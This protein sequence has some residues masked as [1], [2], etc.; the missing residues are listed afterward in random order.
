MADKSFFVDTTRCSACHGC[1]VICKQWN[2]LPATRTKNRGSYQ[3]PEDL[4]SSTFKLVR[5]NEVVSGGKLHWYFF[6]DQCR[7]CLVPPCKE[8]AEGYVDGAIVLDKVTGAVLYTE[9]TKKLDASAFEEI[10]DACPYNIP[11]RNSATGMISKCTMCIDRVDNGL[12]PACVKACPTGAMNF[13][14]RN[15]MLAQAIKRVAEL[16]R[17]GFNKAQL[18]NSDSVRVIYLVVDDPTAYHEFAVDE[19]DVGICHHPPC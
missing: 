16:K 1:Q 19:I 10:K 6:P 12:T 7:H 11:R 3:N 15:A 5:F 4:S 2:D 13:G 8:T 9:K 18:L 17:K 14:N